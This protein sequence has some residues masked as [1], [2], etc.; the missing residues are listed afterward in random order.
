MRYKL[1]EEIARSRQTVDDDPVQYDEHEEV[2]VE[3]YANDDGMWSVKVT[4]TSDPTLSFPLQKFPDEGSANH[5]ARQCADR[6]IRKKMNEVR[7]IV[8]TLILESQLGYQCNNHSLGW[9]DDQGA[10]INCGGMSHG[11]WLYRYHYN[12]VVP[13]GGVEN[14]FGWIKVSNAS[15]IFL[16]GRSW[17]EVTEGQVDALIEMWG[18][19]SKHSR[20]IQRDTETFEVLF[21][22]IESDEL[23]DN[24]DAPSFKMTIPDFLGLYGGRRAIDNFYGM[25]LGE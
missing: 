6:I 17:D 20:W 21:G 24:Y 1:A 13:E 25:L 23:P 19:C 16:A 10:W 5:Y 4:C 18:E 8:R 11:E 14:P 7:S 2:N 22:I 9:V 3:T 15:Q 12:E